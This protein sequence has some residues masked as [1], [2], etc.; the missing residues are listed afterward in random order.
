MH[1]SARA[2]FDLDV[3]YDRDPENIE[4]LVD[5][6]TPLEP[7]LRGAP[8]GLPFVFDVRTVSLGLNFTLNTTLGAVDL[9]GEIAGGGT[10][11][12]LLPH[13]DE[14]ELFGIKCPCINLDFLIR[15]KQA[16]GRPRDFD[17]IAEL[18]AIRLMNRDNDL[19]S[20]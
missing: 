4:R 20:P 18:K 8:S 17:A 6:L 19:D 15:L 3:V 13:S 10:F 12:D 11:K 1:G 14:V 2:T 5:A 16:S 7:Y 9:F